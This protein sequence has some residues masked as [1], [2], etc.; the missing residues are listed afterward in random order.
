MT[1]AN[2]DDL[3]NWVSE[4]RTQEIA[5]FIGGNDDLITDALTRADDEINSYIASL[6]LDLTTSVPR[7]LKNKACA[8]ARYF[9]WSDNASDR[10]RADYTDA[11]KFL[12]DAAAGIVSLGDSGGATQV[13]SAGSPDFIAADRTFDDTTLRG[14]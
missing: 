3:E 2:R 12:K 14:F 13:T 6:G 10:V 5:T 8:I 4:T 7:V 1:Y 11:I 9:L